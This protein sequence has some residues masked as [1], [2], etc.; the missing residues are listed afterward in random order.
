LAAAANGVLPQRMDDMT[1]PF[2]V[3]ALTRKADATMAAAR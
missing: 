1:K 2:E 3:A